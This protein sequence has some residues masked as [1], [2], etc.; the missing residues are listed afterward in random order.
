M[1]DPASPGPPHQTRGT[2]S[3]SQRNDAPQV[4]RLHQGAPFWAH[5]LTHRSTIAPRV[6]IVSRSPSCTFFATPSS[7]RKSSPGFGLRAGRIR[8]GS[9]LKE[10]GP[11]LALRSAARSRPTASSHSTASPPASR[12]RAPTSLRSKRSARHLGHLAKP[13][14][15]LTTIGEANPFTVRHR[16]VPVSLSC[17]VPDRGISGTESRPPA[18]VRP[19]LRLRRPRCLLP[20]G[21]YR[22]PAFAK[23]F[24]KVH[25]RRWTP[26]SDQH[27]HRNT[28][29]SG[30]IFSS[31]SRVLR[32]AVSM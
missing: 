10:N 9:M 26:P 4:E 8:H 23:G 14:G 13:P 21:S 31:C 18:S 30:L 29:T 28:T 15:I 19:L 11:D 5:A 6:T 3:R 22:N 1:D 2:A 20:T 32:I 27:P 12:P 25:R 7:S 16:M 17:S 24:L